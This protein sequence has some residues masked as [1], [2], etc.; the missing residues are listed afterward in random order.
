MHIDTIASIN[1]EQLA[2]AADR[3]LLRGRVSR[4]RARQWVAPRGPVSGIPHRPLAEG[5]QPQIVLPPR[6][7]RHPAPPVRAPQLFMI[8]PTARTAPDR[9]GAMPHAFGRAP[10]TSLL[11]GLAV[12]L[13]A[14][15]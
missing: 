11:T 14:M 6:Q 7:T 12:E 15:R 4:Q 10:A 9:R 1:R 5:S 13:A 3:L 2:T 8:V